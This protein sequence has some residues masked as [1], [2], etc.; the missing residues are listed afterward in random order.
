ARACRPQGRP[1][2]CREGVGRRTRAASTQ[3]G[4]PAMHAIQESLRPGTCGSEHWLA[5]SCL[6]KF[7]IDAVGD[8]WSEGLRLRR[9]RELPPARGMG[10]ATSLG[11]LTSGKRQGTKRAWHAFACRHV[12][13]Y[14]EGAWDQA[15]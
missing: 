4:Q 5:M 3:A 7:G 6:A 8:P 10:A 1:T 2:W 9:D 14:A 13:R 11:R 15:I 12:Q